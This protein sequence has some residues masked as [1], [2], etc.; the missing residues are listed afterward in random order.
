LWS[1]VLKEFPTIRIA[2]SEGGIGWIPYFLERADYVHSRHHYW[3]HQDFGGRMPS[4][5]WREHMITCF[6][7]DPV[8]IKNR[9][10]IG[11]DTITW[12]CDYPHSD[13]T[14]PRSPEIL[15]RSL[16]GVPDDEI[17][18]ITHE[19]A[20]RFFSA[21]PFK[22]RPKDQ[23][24]VGALRAESPD[25]DLSVKSQGGKPPTTEKRPVTT[26]DVMQQLA[27]VYASVP[28]AAES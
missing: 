14:W 12:E 8:G 26:A 17:N 24:R 27:S 1:R 6:I 10:G 7:D 19:N 5:V 28:E 25:V 9:H 21:D 3:T 18:K 22:Y 4:Q 15:W 16:E 11:I 13:T 2:M 20:L 23:C